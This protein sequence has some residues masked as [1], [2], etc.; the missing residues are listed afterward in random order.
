MRKRLF[1]R[2]LIIISL[3]FSVIVPISYAR[4]VKENNG[5]GN[6]D[7]AKWNIILNNKNIDEVIK[8]DLFKTINNSSLKNETN[9]IAP[10]T[11]GNITLNIKNNS[12]VVAEGTI[13]LEELENNNNIP[14]VYSLSEDGE[15]VDINDFIIMNNEIIMPETEKE[16]TIYW[17]WDFYKD[18]NQNQKD[19]DLGTNGTAL[20]EIGINIRINQ[21][22]N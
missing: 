15:Y 7:V 9:I 13:L 1:V 3:C 6:L 11:S 5:L 19:N 2:V 16:I 8:L 12:E 14:I 22:V 18:Y 4:Y 20:F 21:K 10:G 17:K